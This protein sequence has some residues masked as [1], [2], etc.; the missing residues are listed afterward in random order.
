MIDKQIA[1]R[2]YEYWEER[3][4]PH[5]SSEVDWYRAV[6]DLKRDRNL[7][8]TLPSSELTNRRL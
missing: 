7:H 3:G 6:E 8:A 2:A 4:R 1:Q 5:G